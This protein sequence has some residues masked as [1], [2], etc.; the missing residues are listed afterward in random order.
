M[1]KP[2]GI[3][4]ADVIRDLQR[5]FV[6]SQFWK[7]YLDREREARQNESR[8]RY[9]RRG[10]G[11]K[12][13]EVKLGHGGTLDP[14]ATGVL[15][16][17][18]GKGTKELPN[19]LGCTKTYETVVL[20][21]R[22]TDTY[23]RLGKIVSGAPY[24]HITREKVEG[25]LNA[26]RGK[27]MQRPSIYSALKMKGKKLYEYARE[28]VDPPYEIEK[29]PVE[30]SDLRILEWYAPD[31]H[32][33]SWPTDEAG[34]AEKRAVSMVNQAG[35]PPPPKNEE[36]KEDSNTSSDD[37]SSLKRKDGDQEEG[38]D[39][40]STK[41]TK[42]GNDDAAVPSSEGKPTESSA[43]KT[44]QESPAPADDGQENQTNESPPPAVKISL[45]VSSGFYVR[46]F[47]H[48][49]G[50]ALNSNAIMSEL[51]RTRQGDF[52]LEPDRIVEYQDF[53]AGEDVWGPKLRSLMNDYAE[54]SLQRKGELNHKEVPT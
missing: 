7:P 43:E 28:G 10:K 13:I 54:K 31:Q 34:S 16:I 12:H 2:G 39:K 25:V 23:D 20:F 32:N 18:A 51:V 45:T 35:T 37:Q 1:R 11:R 17:G 30:V 46:S 33:Y 3:S 24:E 40:R 42:T 38:Q 27:I 36:K 26:F 15:I 49:L 4:S 5:H 48:D 14:M 21:G 47:A 9:N 6:P 50:L 41:R 22:A 52:T 53:E 44:G 8:S 29:R 19:F